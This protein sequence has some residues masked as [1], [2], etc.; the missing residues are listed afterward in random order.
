MNEPRVVQIELTS[1]ELTLLEEHLNRHLGQ[2]D[3]ELVRTENHAL[4]H[5]IAHEVKVLESVMKRLEA[6]KK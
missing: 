5:A 1:E 4:A 6:A 2:V 3:K